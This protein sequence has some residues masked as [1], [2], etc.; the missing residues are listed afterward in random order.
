MAPKT[1]KPSSTKTADSVDAAYDAKREFLAN[2]SHELRTP[3]NGVIGMTQLLKTTPLDERQKE[4]LECLEVS[5][6]SLMYLLNDILDLASIDTGRI[7]LQPS[8]FSLRGTITNIVRTQ[9][10]ELNAKGLAFTTDIPTSIPDALSGDQL[11]AKQVIL[12]LLGNAVKF[13]EQ[14][15]IGLFVKQLE[16]HNDQILLQIS[17]QDTGIGMK[18]ELIETLFTPFTQADSSRS[19]KFGGSGLGLTISSRLVELMGGRIWAE[20]EAGVG[21]T[22]HVAL[23]FTVIRRTAV[24]LLEQPEPKRETQWEAAPLSILLAEDNAISRKFAVTLLENMGHTVV[25]ASDG[26]KALGW[27][28]KDCF[29][30]VL[31]DIQMPVMDGVASAAAMRAVEQ[32]NG[33]RHTP[34]IALTAHAMQDEMELLLNSGFDGYVAKPFEVSALIEEMQRV[35]SLDV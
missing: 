26:K 15:S 29:D 11:R 27:F 16:Q 30:L 9:Q 35:L 19:R 8:T 34:V 7:E 28:E 31:M 33:G 14:G 25:S 1:S 21:S 6:Q 3:M 12:N 2:M 20:S 13:T 32:K 24:E 17:I 23:P 22:F 18:P 4:Y 5:A 10:Y